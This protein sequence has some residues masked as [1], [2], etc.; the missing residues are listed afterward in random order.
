VTAY[1]AAGV[2]VW[3]GDASKT[4]PGGNT[5]GIGGPDMTWT[6][7]YSDTEEFS[8]G[9]DECTLATSW[10][11]GRLNTNCPG[12]QLPAGPYRITGE[13]WWVDGRYGGRG[14]S[15]S[16]TITISSKAPLGSA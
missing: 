3:D 5:C 12:T 11:P 2:D 10:A 9:Q 4:I 6:A 15:A 8:W 13:F 7:G 1:N 16:A 14:P